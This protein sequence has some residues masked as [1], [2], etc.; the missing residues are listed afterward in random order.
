MTSGPDLFPPDPLA[1]AAAGYRQRLADHPDDAEALVNL[2]V[3]LQLQGQLDPAEASY[4]QALALRP[5]LAEAH[6]NLGVV[7]QAL[8]RLDPAIACFERALALRPDYQDALNG[9]GVACHARGWLDR[10][11]V[12][13]R[14]V[15]ALR[16]DHAEAHTNLAMARLQAGDLETGF[17]ELE[18]R[19]RVQG[20]TDRLPALPQPLW[21]GG[22]LSGRRLLVLPEQGAGDTLQFVRYLRLLKART[23]VERVVVL[24][25]KPLARLLAPVAGLDQLVV[26]GEDE[27]PAFDCYVRLLSLPQRLGTGGDALAAAIPY[28]G[29]APAQIDA[30][31]RQLAAAAADRPG[32][33]VGLVWH[34]N[35]RQPNNRKR[36]LPD[37]LWTRLTGLPGIVWFSLQPAPGADDA[38]RL[39]AAGVIDLGPT[40]TD[41][42]DT[43]A[44]I[45][46][47]DLVITVDTGVANLAG[48]LGRPDWVLLSFAPDWRW[49][50]GCDSTPWYPSL[51]LF[52]Q[53]QPGDWAA[54]LD[55]VTAA[56]VRRLGP[57]A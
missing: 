29:A 32:L 41:W 20:R 24:A 26:A 16:P 36:S 48:A 34:G 15:L 6:N 30:R 1:A 53:P 37:G 5:D 46:A 18:W 23:G 54:V 49:Q 56:L 9:L 42:S 40:L 35:P 13:F 45:A 4:R 44:V 52:R 8:D 31:R 2:G 39:A 3:I 55:A 33:K 57:A 51:R 22:D 17:G 25:P 38:R 10:A 19:W 12:C 50:L 27:P 21:P 28:L 47:L 11:A 14:Q 7:L 43:A